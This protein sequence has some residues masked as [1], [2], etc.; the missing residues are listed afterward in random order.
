MS[1]TAIGA[2]HAIAHE[3]RTMKILGEIKGITNDI[4]KLDKYFFIAPEI[5]QI[6]QD[7]C[8]AFDIEDYNAKRDEHH[9]LIGNKNLILNKQ[10]NF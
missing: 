2:D 7:F 8:D 1:F 4:N 10:K 9:E 5:N 3:N 6:I